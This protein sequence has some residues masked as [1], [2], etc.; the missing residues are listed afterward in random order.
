M[1]VTNVLTQVVNDEI[2][3]MHSDYDGFYL[4]GKATNGVWRWSDGSLIN[5]S[6]NYTNWARGEPKLADGCLYISVATGGEWEAE[7]CPIVNDAEILRCCE[8]GFISPPW[9]H[10][11]DYH[12]HNAEYMQYTHRVVDRIPLPRSC[13]HE[14]CHC[15]RVLWC[16]W[17]TVPRPVA[18]HAEVH[19]VHPP[20]GGLLPHVHPHVLRARCG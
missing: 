16:S 5:A 4:G 19:A 12:N 6:T 8:T 13:D 20:R 18:L 3:A 9:D 11:C 10:L 15:A 2:V 1:T 17:G 14:H 7:A